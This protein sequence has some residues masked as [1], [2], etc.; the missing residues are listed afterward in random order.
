[1]PVNL[2]IGLDAFRL[3]SP[4]RYTSLIKSQDGRSILIAYNPA[5][6]DLMNSHRLSW[7]V[8]WEI[9][10]Y[11]TLSPTYCFTLDDY[12]KIVKEL[13]LSGGNIDAI[14]VGPALIS[15]AK[16]RQRQAVSDF[17]DDDV[18]VEIVKSREVEI[19]TSVVPPPIGFINPYAELDREERMLNLTSDERLSADDLGSRKYGGQG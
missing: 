2:C 8:Q 17:G 19:L 1:M 10:R 9:T 3:H 6:Q 14:K 16:E 11:R 7:A 18:D 4:K 15:L 5:L 12:T 13:H